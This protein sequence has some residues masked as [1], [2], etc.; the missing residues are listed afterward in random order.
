M[1]RGARMAR[2]DDREYR[3]YFEGG[4]NAASRD[5]PPA[6]WSLISVNGPLVPCRSGGSGTSG[7][8]GPDLETCPVVE[9]Q[10]PKVMMGRRAMVYGRRSTP[11]PRLRAI[12]IDFVGVDVE[13]V[14]ASGHSLAAPRRV[15]PCYARFRP[16]HIGTPLVTL[17]VSVMTPHQ[18]F[19]RLRL[20]L[21]VLVAGGLFPS[22]GFAQTAELRGVV[23]DDTGGVLPGVTVTIKQ[24]STGIE[25]TTV[26][27]EYGLF[28]APALQPGPYQ[29]TSELQGFKTDLKSL[30]LTVGDV[31]E[32]RVKLSVGALSETVQVVA[33]A[34]Q[35]E[36]TKSDLSGVV[37]EKQLAELPVLN[38]GFVG[39]AQLLPGGGPSRSGDARFG[40]Q[41]A[42]GGSNVRSMYTMQIDG[43]DL[44]HPIYGMAVV[45]VN[46]DAVQEF[47]V[48][49]NQY[50]A[51]YSR[52]GT[53][54]VNVLTRSGTNDWHGLASYYGRDDA[55][56]A[57]NTF[58]TSKPPFDSTRFSGTFGGPIVKNKAHFFGAVERLRQDSV[59]IIALPANNPFATTWNGVYGNA[60]NETTVDGKVD[61]QV[62]ARHMLN[63]R[64]LHDD[65]AQ[66]S[67]YV[68]AE[69]YINKA[70]D[71]AGTWNWNLSSSVLNTVYFGY[72]DQDTLR[73]QSTP[74]SQ[75][76]P[77]VIHLGPIAESPAGI[78]AQTLAAERNVLLGA[79][80]PRGEVRHADGVRDPELRGGLL[81]RRRLG[82]QHRPA[83]QRR[84]PGDGAVPIHDRIRARD[85]GIP[86][87]RVGVL[88]AGR[89]E[90]EPACH[91]QPRAAL[92]LRHQPS[93]QRFHRAARR[94]S[95]LRRAVESGE[96]AARKRLLAP[97]AAPRL[98]VGHTG[99]RPA[100]RPRRLGLV[101]GAQPPVV[102]HPRP[103][104]QQPVHGGGDQPGPAAGLSRSDGR[105]RRQVGWRLHQDRRRTGAVSAG[106][107]PR[108]A[109]GE[110]PDARLREVAV[111]EHDARSGRDPSE[112]VAPA[113]RARRQPAACRAARHTSAAVS[114]IRDGHA[115]RWH[116]HVVVRRA[117]DLVQEP[118]RVDVVPGVLH[119]GRGR[120]QT[121]PTTTRTRA[122]IPGTR[123]GTTIAGS[124]RTTAGMRSPGRRSSRCRT[125]C[126][127]RR[128]CRCGPAIRGTSPRARI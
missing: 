11:G 94:R 113:D 22:A 5:A 65:L 87:H 84:D 71:L 3:E 26:T 32:I 119:A 37:S 128:S 24:V 50:D 104:G 80:T 38:R 81:R 2:R 120:F 74:D 60:N 118:A 40:I 98:R 21:L 70:H 92:R 49:R 51:E 107:Q 76:D 125:A 69:Q 8:S 114:A 43:S 13:V 112:A 88:R 29:V 78:P 115:H 17:G 18:L 110:Q 73:F 6:R 95:R 54:V 108:S 105:P 28:R 77:P 47:R 42:F 116:D 89:L 63:V 102:Q 4:A 27:D 93:Q 46:Q 124:T 127:S 85:Q 57:R 82:I 117:A 14:D 34:M 61:Y 86:Q 72:L 62:N 20:L 48:L 25:R 100:R 33:G 41:T 59:Q 83:V 52:A 55:L 19:K 91:A 101:R 12:G 10:G 7:G 31:A 9:E 36:T 23:T 39:L 66:P 44:D 79:R 58:A 121:A 68:L 103:G 1:E 126:R 56:N 64:Y 96:V 106:R 53:A 75:V 99:H 35:I 123:S 45:N 15:S 30:T 109:D 97:A 122:P 90:G 67:E 16:R 111:R